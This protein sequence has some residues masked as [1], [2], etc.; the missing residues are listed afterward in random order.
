MLH[1]VDNGMDEPLTWRD[2]SDIRAEIN[3]VGR[4]ITAAHE[5]Y[6]ALEEA[7][8]SL[9]LYADD[10]STAECLEA[11]REASRDCLEQLDQYGTTLKALQKEMSRTLCLTQRM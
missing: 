5:R 11:L 7:L 4:G 2:A 6:T 9:M 3:R 1:F 10:D 8:S